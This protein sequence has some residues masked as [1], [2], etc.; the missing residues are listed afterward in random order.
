MGYLYFCKSYV[1]SIIILKVSC[2]HCVLVFCFFV[3]RGGGGGKCCLY[4]NET[5]AE[6]LK[7]LFNT[8]CL[9]PTFHPDVVL[10]DAVYM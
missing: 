6:A 10:L 3:F 1:V 9:F 2:F 8:G 7:F 4:S 5:V